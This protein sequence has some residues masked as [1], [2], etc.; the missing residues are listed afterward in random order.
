M[1]I[2]EPVFVTLFLISVIAIAVLAAVAIEWAL[3]K[4]YERTD[5]EPGDTTFPEEWASE[6]P[7]RDDLYIS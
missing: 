4:L 3:R 5:D 7:P 2:S 1:Q 6:D